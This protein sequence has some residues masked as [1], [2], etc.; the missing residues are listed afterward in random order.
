MPNLQT[1]TASRAIGAS[2][3]TT[4]SGST[5]ARSLPVQVPVPEKLVRLPELPPEVDRDNIDVED[6]EQSIQIIAKSLH[7]EALG[8]L[9][10]PP[11]LWN[12]AE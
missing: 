3:A 8:E 4:A 6:I 2:R 9:P 10:R 11:K 12:V 1:V 5:M 7:T